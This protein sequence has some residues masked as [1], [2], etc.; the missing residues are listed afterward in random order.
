M[1]PRWNAE[2]EWKTFI[3]PPDHLPNRLLED[4]PPSPQCISVPEALE[5]Y[6]RLTS[7]S[8]PTSTAAVAAPEHP[9]GFIALDVDVS[10]RPDLTLS[11]P[12]DSTLTAPLQKVCVCYVSFRRDD[13]FR[14]YFLLHFHSRLGT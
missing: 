6:D 3:P 9:R 1:A 14:A 8:P 4:D 5:R 10:G 13:D 2:E 7:P 11:P 12:P